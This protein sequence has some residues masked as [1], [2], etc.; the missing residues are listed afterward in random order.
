[1]K[2]MYK[3]IK[4]VVSVFIRP[5]LVWYM[6]KQ[7]YYSKNG[8][9]LTIYPGVFHPGFFFSTGFLWQL[10]DR[11]NLSAKTLLEL[12]AGSGFISFQASAKGAT[13]TASDI[14][15]IAING[16]EYNANKLNLQVNIVRSDL[17]DEIPVNTFDYIIIN[18]PYYPRNAKTEPEKAWFCGADFE[19]FKKLFSQLKEYMSPET[20]V[21]M[22]LSEDCNINMIQKLADREGFVFRL[23]QKKRFI[24]ELNY[25]YQ[26]A[27][28]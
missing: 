23:K 26:I 19:Y 15:S 21:W 12:G 27:I 18:P 28:Q 10:L 17:F 25:I 4:W 8:I 24:W 16:L 3:L 22:S 20:Q 2:P 11:E 7:R 6:K 5:V 9:I 1:M 14:S 13:V